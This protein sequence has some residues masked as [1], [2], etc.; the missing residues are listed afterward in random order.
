MKKGMLSIVKSYVTETYPDEQYNGVTSEIR[1]VYTITFREYDGKTHKIEV[2]PSQLFGMISGG[3]YF[4][5]ME[6]E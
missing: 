2:S 4:A 3:S 6:I 5:L 1:E